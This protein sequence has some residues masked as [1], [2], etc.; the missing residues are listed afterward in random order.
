MEILSFVKSLLPSFGKER[1]S[2][3]ARITLEELRNV[4][5]PSF[6]AAQELIK[7]KKFTSKE[8]ENLNDIFKRN[9]KVEK[10][11]NLI[12]SIT[13]NLPKV[14]EFQEKIQDLIDKRF[15]KDIVIDGI[16]IYK[17]NVIQAQTQL[18]FISQFS[19][20]LLNYIYIVE[21]ESAS[22]D[23]H[24][25][26]DSLSPTDIEY[27]KVNFID[28]INAF[29]IAAKTGKDVGK[30]LEVAPDVVI[31]NNPEAVAAVYDNNKID[32]LSMRTVRNFNNSP[33]F[34]LRLVVA[35]Y[36]VNRYKRM[37]D[38]KQLLELRLLNLNKQLDK[39]PDPKLENEIAYTQSRVDK[40][41]SKMRRI[42]EDLS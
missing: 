29:N 22:G 16:T 40:I 8:A 10:G 41:A 11:N 4:V 5:L 18:S 26:K 20:K 6:E 3:D 15:D 42:E 2:E 23:G 31:G 37:Q 14:I 21:T 19:V 17:A 35:E 34:S 36:Q 33:I 24:Y 28:F 25:T 12:G 1:L 7:T 38:T 13:V 39:S 27:V 32:P 9:V 30:V